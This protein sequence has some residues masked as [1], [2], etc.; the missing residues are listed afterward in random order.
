MR[1]YRMTSTSDV[2]T[3]HPVL[4]RCT[5]PEHCYLVY[6]QKN[7]HK[8]PERTEMVSLHL[9]N[10]VCGKLN[11]QFLT[12]THTHTHTHTIHFTFTCCSQKC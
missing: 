9:K 4:K 5:F 8:K 7:T 10:T 12:I 2:R 1:L 11:K 6:G 3:D